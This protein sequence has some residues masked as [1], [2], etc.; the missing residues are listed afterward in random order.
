MELAAF[1]AVLAGALLHVVVGHR[2]RH[3]IS[4]MEVAGATV[5][6]ALA[7]GLLFVDH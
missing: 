7:I 3:K 5:G 1:E 2:P 6:V 4:A